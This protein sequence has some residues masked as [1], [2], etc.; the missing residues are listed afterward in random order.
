MLWGAFTAWPNGHLPL[1]RARL[2]R[3][4]IAEL[5][6]RMSALPAKADIQPCERH[7]RFVP[8][9]DIPS[10]FSHWRIS[11]IDSSVRR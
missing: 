9:A 5:F 2:V 11:G 3:Q 7:V 6:D 10:E 4:L 1:G 8:K